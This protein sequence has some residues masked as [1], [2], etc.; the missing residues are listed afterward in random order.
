MIACR[1]FDYGYRYYYH[2]RTCVTIRA[3]CWTLKQVLPRRRNEPIWLITYGPTN[4][5]DSPPNA[6]F[7]EK[8]VPVYVRGVEPVAAVIELGTFRFGGNIRRE[9][10]SPAMYVFR[11]EIS[12]FDFRNFTLPARENHRIG[13]VSALLRN[14]KRRIV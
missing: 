4:N 14:E 6:T 8:F 5:D 10:Y 9:N 7:L 12:K 11:S 1:R 3:L 2:Y 13:K